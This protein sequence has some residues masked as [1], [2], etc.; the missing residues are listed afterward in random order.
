MD[1]WVSGQILGEYVS[2]WMD[3]FM[4]KEDSQYQVINPPLH[5]K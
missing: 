5:V 4:N 3:G 1:E 2:G